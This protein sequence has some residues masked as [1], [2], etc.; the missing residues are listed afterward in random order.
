MSEEKI[1]EDQLSADDRSDVIKSDNEVSE[2]K[3]RDGEK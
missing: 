2:E 1:D 3:C